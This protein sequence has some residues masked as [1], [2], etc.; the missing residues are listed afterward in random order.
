MNVLVISNLVHSKVGGAEVYNRLIY[1]NLKDIS[2]FEIPI[3]W[4]DNEKKSM[5]K[6][7]KLLDTAQQI[8]K[9]ELQFPKVPKIIIN[10]RIK[11]IS[12]LGCYYNKKFYSKILSEKISEI[13][14]KYD[15]E[16]IIWGTT[17]FINKKF[18]NKHKDIIYFVQHQTPYNYLNLYYVDYNKT[19]KF[20]KC[21]FVSFLFKKGTTWKTNYFKIMKNII[22]FDCVNA[23]IIKSFYDRNLIDIN[24][25]SQFSVTSSLNH[26]HEKEFD[27]IIP[28]RFTKQKNPEAIADFARNNPNY[29]FFI[30]GE[31]EEK[32]K[33]SN[34]NN[35]NLSRPLTPEEMKKYYSKS[36]FI[37][38]FSYFEGFPL[39]VAEALSFGLPC[40]LAD[41]FPSA[42][43]LVGENSDRGFLFDLND[44]GHQ[45]KINHFINNCDYH[46]LSKNAIDFAK[47][48]LSE[49]EFAKK[50]E[51]V[52]K[53]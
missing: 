26:Q 44:E 9:M 15:I 17:Y 41:T 25:P 16:K 24:I 46:K 4:P 19:K 8:K 27:F 12:R 51:K 38:L 50:W 39:V 42:K 7:V 35:I 10:S 28:I 45:S 18:I 21:D 11:I 1:S 2:F 20:K 3:L 48:K 33:L 6:N 53:S 47:T 40:I 23:D 14:E 31:G 37:I 29:S 22:C 5:Y 13:I 36:K 43:Y 34:I 30:C 49:K 32:Q 52:L